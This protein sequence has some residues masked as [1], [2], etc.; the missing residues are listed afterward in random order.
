MSTVRKLHD[1][2]DVEEEDVEKADVEEE[3]ADEV[4]TE[5]EGAVLDELDELVVGTGVDESVGGAVV[6]SEATTGL[7]PTCESAKPTICHVITVVTTRASIQAATSLHESIPHSPRVHH[8]TRS[9][10]SQAFLK[11]AFVHCARL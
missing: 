9:A 6:A 4:V 1:S 3:D 5:D 10:Q 2:A 7:S 11:T 8:M